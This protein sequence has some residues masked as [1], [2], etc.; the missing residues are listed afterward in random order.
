MRALTSAVF[1]VAVPFGFAPPQ[2][3]QIEEKNP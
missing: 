3:D 2:P 1:A